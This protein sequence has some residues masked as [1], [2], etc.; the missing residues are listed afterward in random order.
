LTHTFLVLVTI[1]LRHEVY[2]KFYTL[3]GG[4]HA[5]KFENHC[6]KCSTVL[7]KLLW[8]F[9]FQEFFRNCWFILIF[10]VIGSTWMNVKMIQRKEAAIPHNL[11]SRCAKL[12][13]MTS[14][15]HKRKLD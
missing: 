1:G 15:L 10:S 5:E 14:W 11:D 6:S 13:I 9:V 4:Q 7:E 3:V 2:R 12:L 8:I